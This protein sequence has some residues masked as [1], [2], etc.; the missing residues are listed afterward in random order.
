MKKIIANID[1]CTG[2]EI[3]TLIC[4][5]NAWEGF[6]THKGKLKVDL[7]DKGV[8]NSVRV[9]QQC[10]NPVCEKVCPVNAIKINEDKGIVEINEDKC[11]G[12][13]ICVEECP[14][15]AIWM[16]KEMKLAYKCDLCGGD[17]LCV[18]YCP[19][20]ALVVVNQ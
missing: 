20:N 3:C 14:Y 4:S 18:K 5:F 1:K 9:C 12:C 13:G 10:E 7:F 11:I 16:N 15:D 17:P 6:N 2:C 8:F 19:A